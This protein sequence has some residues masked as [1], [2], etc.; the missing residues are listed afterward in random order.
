MRC[1]GVVPLLSSS[2]PSLGVQL[3]HAASRSPDLVLLL[4][5]FCPLCSSSCPLL[6]L[7]L[8]SSF[9]PNVL[10]LSS[11]CPSAG[12]QMAAWQRV[13]MTPSHHACAKHRPQAQ[14]QGPMRECLVPSG[15]APGG[16]REDRST[17]AWP[18]CSLSACEHDTM[19][20]L[21]SIE[22]LAKADVLSD[23]FGHILLASLLC[24][25]TPL[26][27]LLARSPNVVLL[28]L[29]RCPV[30]AC[31]SVGVFVVFSSW[32]VPVPLG[33]SFCCCHAV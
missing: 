6:L 2:C 22:A 21:Q 24:F 28:S 18:P 17:A 7:W 9:L 23:L 8:S 19:R 1:P 11:C 10:F 25:F 14:S 12:V 4:S 32:Y 20:A 27:L 3:G 30:A 31:P 26:V 15:K 13:D 33:V 29:W 5:S 16:T